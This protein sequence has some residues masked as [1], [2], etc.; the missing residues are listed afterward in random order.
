MRFKLTSS[1][2]IYPISVSQKQR[3]DWLFT[4]DL[5]N[6]FYFLN[7]RFCFFFV[8][9]THRLNEI[10]LKEHT[11]TIWI[12]YKCYYFRFSCV[13]C[14]NFFEQWK[15][16]YRI[17][18]CKICLDFEYPKFVWTNLSLLFF[19]STFSVVVL[20]ISF[21]LFH[22][23]FLSNKS[24]SVFCLNFL[25]LLHFWFPP[26]WFSVHFYLPLLQVLHV[27]VTNCKRTRFTMYQCNWI[28]NWVQWC[29]MTRSLVQKVC[30]W[31]C[32]SLLHT[33]CR[34]SFALQLGTRQF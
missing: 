12:K 5:S 34:R 7:L 29:L 11:H 17:P 22:Y 30:G 20:M 9:R 14:R 16:A 24:S 6:Y 26:S 21:F 8:K 13:F 19:L 10:F 23:I 2:N 28:L 31:S 1:T 32:F 18:P 15:I 27:S 4:I 3:L 25:F 33:F